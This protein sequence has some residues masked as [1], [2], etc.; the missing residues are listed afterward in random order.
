MAP[1]HPEYSEDALRVA[2]DH[3]RAVGCSTPDPFNLTLTA[4]RGDPPESGCTDAK[5]LR[6]FRDLHSI[7]CLVLG[8]PISDPDLRPWAERSHRELELLRNC[9]AL[10]AAAQESHSSA[11]AAHAVCS[12]KRE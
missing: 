6:R 4:W 2:L 12:R 8:V 7:A 9:Y 1:T 10:A 5:E 3:L 11:L